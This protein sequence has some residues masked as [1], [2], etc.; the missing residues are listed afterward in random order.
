LLHQRGRISNMGDVSSYGPYREI[1]KIHSLEND[2]RIRRCGENF[3]IDWSATMKT[4]SIESQL[5]SNCLLKVQLDYLRRIAK[6]P[7]FQ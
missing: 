2:S 4:Y 3:Q 5:C 1:I 7:L 6:Q